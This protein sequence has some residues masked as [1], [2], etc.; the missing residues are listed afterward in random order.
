MRQ[1]FFQVLQ[2]QN[3]LEIQANN[4]SIIYDYLFHLLVLSHEPQ[5]VQLFNIL[6]KEM[7]WNPDLGYMTAKNSVTIHSFLCQKLAGY[8]LCPGTQPW[9]LLGGLHCRWRRQRV[10]S[11]STSLS[12]KNTLKQAPRRTLHFLLRDLWAVCVGIDLGKG[13]MGSKF[14]F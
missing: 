5:Y 13:M 2:L 6:Y 7:I 10:M 14:C 9:L 3:Q 8:Q 4:H 11:N 1:L 12:G